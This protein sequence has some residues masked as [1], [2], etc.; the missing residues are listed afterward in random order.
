[1]TGGAAVPE[2]QGGREHGRPTRSNS[3]DGG[4]F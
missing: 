3:S 1:M 4:G 2:S